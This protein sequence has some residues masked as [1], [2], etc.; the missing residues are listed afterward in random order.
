MKNTVSDLHISIEFLSARFRFGKV[1]SRGQKSQKS[2]C[3]ADLNCECIRMSRVRMGRGGGARAGQI[4]KK[5]EG[6]PL[7]GTLKADKQPD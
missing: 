6:W 3:T 2:R 7:A 1:C 4:L 5:F